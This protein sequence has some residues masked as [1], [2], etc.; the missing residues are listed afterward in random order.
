M[1]PSVSGVGRS[2]PTP[3]VSNL[4]YAEQLRETWNVAGSVFDTEHHARL[5]G[6]TLPAPR[7][8]G[9]NGELCD[10]EGPLNSSELFSGNRNPFRPSSPPRGVNLLLPSG[11]RDSGFLYE[12]PCLYVSENWYEGSSSYESIDQAQAPSLQT[13]RDT[14][15]APRSFENSTLPC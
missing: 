12:A 11:L 14:S 10:W 6:Q 15:L 13:S 8:Q 7:S 5:R 4:R 1:V 2:A 9:Y 3:S